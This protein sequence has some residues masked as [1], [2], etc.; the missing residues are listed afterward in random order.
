VKAIREAVVARWPGSYILKVHGDRYVPDGTPDLLL[1]V[2]GRFVAIEVKYRRAGESEQRAH[3]KA[4][5]AQRRA[6]GQ[7]ILSGGIAF[8]AT[9]AAEAV[10][11]IEANLS[12]P[13]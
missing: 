3:A 10:A 12:A 11:T 9:S 4:T 7:V 6:L 8:V 1:S 5:D 2:Q 13:S